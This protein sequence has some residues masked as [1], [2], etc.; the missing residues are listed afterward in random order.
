MPERDS[1]S[2][3]EN[4][5]VALATEMMEIPGSSGNE[6]AIVKYIRGRLRSA[7][8]PA[9]DIRTDTVP[10][11]S[12]VGGGSGNLIVRVG[13]SRRGTR[14]LLM[15]HVDTV[16]LCIGSEPVRRG[17]FIESRNPDTGLGGDNRAGAAVVLNTILEIR[18]NGLS[19]P[20]LTL[21]WPVQEEIGMFGVRYAALSLLHRPGLCFNW[22][23]SLPHIATIGATGACN[24]DIRVEGVASHA[25]AHPEQ[26]V[27]AA[28]IAGLAIANL[29]RNDWHGEITKGRQTGTSNIG[30]LSGGH[31]TNV[32]LPD[33]TLRAEA[34]SHSPSFRARIVREFRN[35]FEDAADRVRNRAGARGHVHFH[36][37]PRYDSFRLKRREPCVTVASDAIRLVG[38]RPEYRV[39]NGGL[40]ANWMTARGLP[41]VSLGCGQQAIHT[42][43]EALLVPSFLSACR[44]ALAIAIGAV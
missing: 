26:G 1:L 39:S 41:T 4:E 19:H 28:S 42:V 43:D 22:D 33:L 35:A 17:P 21:F 13:G 2:I 30:A 24:M 29:F 20:P 31:A 14:R 9:R 34:R 36:S 16:P 44:I 11:R 27:S 8:I 15:A 40:D 18:R 38:L 6:R 3:S 5:A 10:A 37:E 12:P 23:G 25:G 32:V 7:R